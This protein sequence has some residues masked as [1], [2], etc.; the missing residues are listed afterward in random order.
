[1]KSEDEVSILHETKQQ[2]ETMTLKSIHLLANFEYVSHARKLKLSNRFLPEGIH[3]GPTFRQINQ[4]SES[5]HIVSTTDTLKKK[6]KE[7]K[8]TYG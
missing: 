5:N 8:Y 7:R 2:V 3:N 1:M 6:R 4:L